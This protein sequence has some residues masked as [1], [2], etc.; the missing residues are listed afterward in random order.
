MIWSISI[1]ASP[2]NGARPVSSSYKIAPSDHTS[3]RPS[4]LFALRIISGDEYGESPN[5]AVAVR[6]PPAPGAAAAFISL[7]VPKSISLTSGAPPGRCVRNSVD[8]WISRTMMPWLCVSAT[9]SAAWRMRS[10]ASER[11]SAP[12]TLRYRP[13]SVPSRYSRTR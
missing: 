13:R 9:A 11:A 7:A 1:A 12:L 2:M 8:G 4:A 10:T 3:V 6:S 5:I